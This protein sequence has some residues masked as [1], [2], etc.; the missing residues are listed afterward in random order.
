MAVD[1]TGVWIGE[2]DQVEIFDSAGELVDTWH[3]SEQLG[4]VTAVGFGGGGVFPADAQAR[5]VR[6]FDST[7]RLLNNIDGRHRKGGFHIPNGVVDF[8]IDDE[9]VVHVANPGMHRV[10]RYRPD[11]E[12]LGFFGRFDGLDPEGFPGCCNPT[13][14]AVTGSTRAGDGRV[15]VS[16]KAAPC[17]KVY[18]GDGR[19]LSVI[20]EGDV[21]DPGAK[22]MELAVDSRGRVYVADTVRLRILIFAPEAEA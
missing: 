20:A 16:E 18:D 10:E 17:A 21:F 2:E 15:I 9:G 1:E 4:R 7:G 22:N 8:A 12:S 5:W 11:G 13:N 19:L 6:R 3:D 14:V